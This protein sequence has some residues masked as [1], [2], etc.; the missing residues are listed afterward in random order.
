[1]DYTNDVRYELG[2]RL[3]RPVDHRVYFMEYAQ[4][5][6][7]RYDLTTD[8]VLDTLVGSPATYGLIDDPIN[9]VMY[10]TTTDFLTTG[11]LRDA[12]QRNDPRQRA[13]RREPRAPGP[14]RALQH[15]KAGGVHG[16]SV[17]NPEPAEGMVT[18]R[19][20]SARQ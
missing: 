7:N 18:L 8:A 14:G 12:V 4:N 10:G 2:L 15:R 1:M 16:N 9:H 6:L 3:L 20:G 17:R 11:E 19:L 5:Q 13:G